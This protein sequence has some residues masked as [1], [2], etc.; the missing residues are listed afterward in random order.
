MEETF[1]SLVKSTQQ[2]LEQGAQFRGNKMPTGNALRCRQD[3]EVDRVELH[4]YHLVEV[5]CVVTV[6]VV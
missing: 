3:V 1:C 2:L 6:S 5:G 4:Q